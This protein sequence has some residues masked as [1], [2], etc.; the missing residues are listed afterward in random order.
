[1]RMLFVAAVLA[2]AGCTANPGYNMMEGGMAGAAVGCVATIFIGCVPG[3]IA[4][5]AAGAGAGLLSTQPP[6]EGYYGP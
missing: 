5:G 4:V 1:M 6:Y 2:L 3:A